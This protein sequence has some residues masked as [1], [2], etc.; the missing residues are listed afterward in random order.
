MNCMLVKGSFYDFES[1]GKALTNVLSTLI[2]SAIFL[3]L[4]DCNCQKNVFVN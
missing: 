4:V 1:N 2:Y 3:H